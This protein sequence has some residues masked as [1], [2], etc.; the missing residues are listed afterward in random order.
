M[1]R[2][3]VKNRGGQSRGNI[4]SVLQFEP[5]KDAMQT[6][7]LLHMVP[8]ASMPVAMGTNSASGRRLPVIRFTERW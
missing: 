1:F 7:A 2:P 8:A 3:L 5:V 4:S 6:A